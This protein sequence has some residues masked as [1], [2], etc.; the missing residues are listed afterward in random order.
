V[1]IGSQTE[2]TDDTIGTTPTQFRFN[3]GSGSKGLT[4]FQI[5][6]NG[7]NNSGAAP[8]IHALNVGYTDRAMTG[9]DN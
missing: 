3:F 6:L 5:K 2:T 7:D 9:A 4:R 1:T 8:I